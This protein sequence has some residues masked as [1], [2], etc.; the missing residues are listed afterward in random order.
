[1]LDLFGLEAGILHEFI[2]RAEA[3][4]RTGVLQ[5]P[6]V[7]VDKD[8]GG[9]DLELDYFG[10]ME[11]F[12]KSD[13]DMIKQEALLIFGSHERFNE[14]IASVRRGAIMAMAMARSIALA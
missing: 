13:K 4:G 7:D 5:S 12:R 1:M 11:L 3:G 2:V 14:Y 10:Q 6:Q 9:K 8:E